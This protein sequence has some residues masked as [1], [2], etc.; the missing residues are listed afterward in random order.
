MF[1]RFLLSDYAKLHEFNGF[2]FVREGDF[3]EQTERL[4]KIITNV[5]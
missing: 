4:W 5:V 1:N 2:A 3:S